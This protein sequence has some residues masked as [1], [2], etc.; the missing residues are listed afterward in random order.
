LTDLNP[1]TF[2]LNTNTYPITRG[3]KVE[4]AC[5]V[6]LTVFG[7][8]SQLKLWKT[9]KERREKNAAARLEREQN[10]EREEE[11][12]GRKMEDNFTRERA[13]WE[14]TYGD[15]ALQQDS[16]IDPSD[17]SSPKTSM[18]VRER[19]VSSF[20]SVEMT[21][22]PPKQEP[23]VK[24]VHSESRVS[25]G[26]MVTVTV[27][28]EDDEIQHIDNDGKPVPPPKSDIGYL[29]RTLSVSKNS[30]RASSEIVPFGDRGLPRSTSMRSSIGD[31]ILPRSVS[32]N[33]VQTP[34]P[35]PPAVVPLPFTIPQEEDSR[36][37]TADNASVS[38]VPESIHESQSIRRSLS[39]RLSGG[40]VLKRLSANRM[41]HQEMDEEALIVPHIEDDRSSLAATLDDDRLSLPD[42]SP[43]RS[44]MV[45]G[46]GDQD[47]AVGESTIG[48]EE[49]ASPKAIEVKGLTEAKEPA[50]VK[51][52]IEAK[53][54][55]M[56]PEANTNVA[57]DATTAAAPTDASAEVQPKV[58]KSLTIS[59]DPKP[60][61]T[62][63]KHTPLS[64]P[65]Q[66]SDT[67]VA[68][69]DES[70]ESPQQSKSNKLGAQS[71]SSHTGSQVGLS[72]EVLPERLSKVALSY[73]TNEWAK[74]LET[75]EKPDLDDIPEP[76]SPG[77]KVSHGVDE[78]PTPVS[79]EI[80]GI[81]PVVVSKRNSKRTSA[82]TVYRNDNLMRS[83]SAM[84]R[85]SLVTPLHSMASTPALATGGVSRT[86]S[87]AQNRGLRSSSTPY[88][89]QTQMADLSGS[90]MS[91]TPS[92]LPNSTLMGQRETL[93]RSKPVP[94]SFQNASSPNLLS[95]DPENLTLAQRKQ[96][97]H[98]KPPLAS[99]Q[100]RQSNWAIGGQM[101]GFDSHQPRRYSGGND[102]TRR[103]VMLAN[104]RESMRHDGPQVQNTTSDESRRMALI[105]ERRQKELEKQQQ[106]MAAQ[107]RESVMGNMMRSNQMLDAHREAMR[108]MQ[109]K[110]NRNAS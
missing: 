70:V 4:V 103:E 74:H 22:L 99:Q 98:Q 42:V 32:R 39:K 8:I 73:R 7:I 69:P 71:V 105:N 63:L 27:L 85:N 77:V 48:T 59:T 68:T 100:W 54:P 35:P 50:E 89:T 94:Q 101:Q 16:V 45:P 24:G 9:V 51:V 81:E 102:P 57:R 25:T 91:N 58:Q 53:E 78:Q 65:R 40:A 83:T 106:E 13:Q 44:P 41:S 11:E 76:E 66:R 43:P 49:D 34:V 18:S 10:L 55:A 90:R 3:I 108:R 6:L 62:A 86:G 79:D 30:A 12:L 14:A 20:E 72:K 107:Q 28:P 87:R 92:P 46:F 60:G 21:T 33:S 31:R 5:I 2:P 26:P 110:A 96:M 37:E 36:S 80:Q 47:T 84:S 61:L 93:V 19:G 64:S 97:M 109:A 95:E 104:W 23:S 75:A 15:K 56:T 88:L 38:A 67:V 1:N 17:K 82:G 52:P 29:N